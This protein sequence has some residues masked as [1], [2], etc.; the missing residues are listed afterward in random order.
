[1]AQ[2]NIPISVLRNFCAPIDGCAAVQSFS[3]ENLTKG[4][5]VRADEDG[6]EMFNRNGI[7]VLYISSLEERRGWLQKSSFDIIGK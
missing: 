4:I 2:P 3:T 7:A 6:S 5:L 1:M